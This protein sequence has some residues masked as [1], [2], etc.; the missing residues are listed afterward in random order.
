MR[1]VSGIWKVLHVLI[2]RTAAPEA[3]TVLEEER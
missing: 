2:A 3:L 1:D